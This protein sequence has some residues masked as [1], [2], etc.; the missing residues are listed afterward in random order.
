MALPALTKIALMYLGVNPTWGLMI[1]VAARNADV[2]LSLR[3]VDY[4]FQLK[5][6]AICVLFEALCYCGCATRRRMAATA[7]TRG[8]TVAPCPMDSP[9]MPFFCVVKRRRRKVEVEQATGEAVVAG[10]GWVP[11]NNWIS[12]RV[13]GVETVSV[14]LVQQLPGRRRKKNAIQSRSVVACYWGVHLG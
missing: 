8:R 6:T 3:T 10:L 7:H 5:M 9:L 4:R 14:P 2:I 12:S 13:K 11:T 1:L